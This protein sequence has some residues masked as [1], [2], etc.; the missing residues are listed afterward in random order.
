MGAAVWV[1][2]DDGF[3]RHPKVTSITDTALRLHLEGMCYAAHYLTDGYVPR[4]LVARRFPAARS[5]ERA[6]LWEAE[7]DGSG[8]RIHDWAEYQPRAESVLKRR[9]SDAERLR[10][11]R[12][13]NGT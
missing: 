13:R 10:K 7:Q 5:L 8:W 2:L 6:G 12:E 9:S 1:K 4:S 3:A 11:W